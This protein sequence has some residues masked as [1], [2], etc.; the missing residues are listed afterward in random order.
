MSELQKFLPTLSL[1][2]TA[3]DSLFQQQQPNDEIVWRQI[4]LQAEINGTIFLLLS[5]NTD[6]ICS[7]FIRNWYLCH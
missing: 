2:T 5:E 4:A 6:M 3:I 7:W 1:L